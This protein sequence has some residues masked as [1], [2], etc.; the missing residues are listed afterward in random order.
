MAG[1][2]QDGPIQ[3]GEG[4]FMDFERRFPMPKTGQRLLFVLG[5]NPNDSYGAGH[6]LLDIDGGVVRW[7][8][9]DLRP[10]RFAAGK[11]PEEFIA[12]LEEIA[13]MANGS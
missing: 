11:T 13:G 5:R 3:V 4:K 6:G 9:H 2:A 7:A 8:T 12:E 1:T 10:T